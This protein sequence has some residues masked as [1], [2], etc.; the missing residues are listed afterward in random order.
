MKKTYEGLADQ[1]IFLKEREPESLGHAS[2]LADQFKE[3]RYTDKVNLTFNG[4]DRSQSRS[5]SR[6]RSVSPP[7]GFH[8]QRQQP[9]RCPCF[10]CGD[11]RHIARFCPDRHKNIRMR[12]AT[13]HTDYRGRSRS[14][15]KQVRFHS[16]KQE[17]KQDF[18]EYKMGENQV[19]GA[20]IIPTDAFTLLL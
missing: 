5:R 6:S 7:R 17:S 1:R 13:A 20:C 14:Q 12:V 3:A 9:V 10:I 15:K 19:C 2:K 18:D 16:Y 8:P 11:R 4:N